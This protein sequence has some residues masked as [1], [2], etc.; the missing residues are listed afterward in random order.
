M[1]VIRLNKKNYNIILIKKKFL[2]L[3]VG[4]FFFFFENEDNIVLSVRYYGSAS[5]YRASLEPH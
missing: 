2:I 1:C 3:R 5:L 4:I